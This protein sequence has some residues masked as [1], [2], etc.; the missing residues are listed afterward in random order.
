MR[1]S[2]AARCRTARCSYDSGSGHLPRHA[3]TLRAQPVQAPTA[4]ALLGG[5]APL[6]PG[7]P[8]SRLALGRPRDSAAGSR[9]LPY[10]HARRLTTAPV[11]GT[12]ARVITR[13]A[14]RG[15]IAACDCSTVSA[16]GG[17]PPSGMT[18]TRWR[19]MTVR[20][21]KPKPVRHACGARSSERRGQRL[22]K[23]RSQP[24]LQE[25]GT[26]SQAS[27]RSAGRR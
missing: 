7:Q 18:I 5:A 23:G 15:R 10:L 8:R 20:F 13:R 26:V 3:A 17:V 6:V 24:R 27:I 1:P 11:R 19:R 4:G 2:A 14:D 22:G 16:N 25:A 21:T 9:S 12:D